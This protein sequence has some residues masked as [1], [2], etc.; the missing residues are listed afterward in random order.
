M[1]KKILIIE[2][3]RFILEALE[4]TLAHEGYKT[5]SVQHLDTLKFVD[6]TAIELI[7][8]DHSLDAY[9]GHILCSKLKNQ[10]ISKHIPVILLSTHPYLQKISHDAGAD[11]YLEKPFDI[12][13][14]LRIVSNCFP[15]EVE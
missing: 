10:A 9:N 1:H 5:Q 12:G 13:K 8:I 11:D 7:L 15:R 2:N 4:L 3:D 6:W 14:L